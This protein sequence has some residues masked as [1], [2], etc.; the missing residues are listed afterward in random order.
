MWI[1][2]ITNNV[3]G[4]IYIG[5]T[6]YDNPSYFGSGILIKE[7][8]KKYGI[9]KFEKA[10]IDTAN[11]QNELDEKEKYWIK[12]HNSQDHKI[13]YNIADG[14]YNCFTMTDDIAKKISNTWKT[15]Y[16]QGYI[17]NRIGTIMSEGVKS[18]ISNSNKGKVRSDETKKKLSDINIGKILS[19]ETK[20]KLSISHTGKCLSEEHKASIGKSLIGRSVS[21]ETKLKLHESNI[22]KTQKHSKKV[23]ATNILTNEILN[24]N[25]ISQASRFF[26]TYRSYIR[27]NKVNGWNI[28]LYT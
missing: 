22:N 3:N 28:T 12:F 15:K 21:D 25:N 8:I 27:S 18:K 26:N 19:K 16:E 9:D 7:A 24:F 20:K 5:Q 1:Y 11:D 23:I 10:Y 13:G 4:K 2:K 14:G 6:H 17:N